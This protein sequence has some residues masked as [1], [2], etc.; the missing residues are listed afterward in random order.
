MFEV[1]V[2]ERCLLAIESFRESLGGIGYLKFSGIPTLQEN[3]LKNASYTSPFKEI[4][5]LKFA[6]YFTGLN[7]DVHILHT[8]LFIQ[9]LILET[10]TVY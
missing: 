9:P 10:W 2:N 1:F 6:K 8:I 3:A 4:R 7:L 5:Y